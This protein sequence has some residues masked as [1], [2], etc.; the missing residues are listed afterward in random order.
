MSTDGLTFTLSRAKFDIL[1]ATSV[2][3]H[4][5]SLGQW[6]VEQRSADSY[7]IRLDRSILNPL[8]DELIELV[9]RVGF[10]ENYNLTAEGALIEDLID[11]LFV[12]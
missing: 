12:P 1:L 4:A 2:L 5:S 6:D 3:N 8:R 11:G 7:R 10:D 9:V